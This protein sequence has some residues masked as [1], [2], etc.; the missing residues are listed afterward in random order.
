MALESIKGEVLKE[1]EAVKCFIEYAIEAQKSGYTKAAQFFLS[2]AQEDC[3]HA[4]LYA[5]E[6]DKDYTPSSKDRTIIDITKSYYELE[7]SAIERISEMYKEAKDKNIRSVYPFLT[8]MMSRHSE[9]CYKAKKL[10]QKIEILFSSDALSD[11]EE[12]FEDD[13]EETQD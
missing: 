5:R 2:E 13:E 7:Y 8:D 1:M 3:K 10:L 9:D 6:I 11:I 4:F 12:L